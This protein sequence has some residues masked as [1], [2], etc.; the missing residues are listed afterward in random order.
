MTRRERSFRILAGILSVMMLYVAVQNGSELVEDGWLVSR[1]ALVIGMYLLIPM[2]GLY[3][4]GGQRAVDPVIG[5][6]MKA[7]E[8]RDQMLDKLIGKYVEM[9]PQPEH[10]LPRRKRSEEAQPASDVS[11]AEDDRG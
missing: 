7:A 6:L 8:L 1:W 10:L 5:W 3:A 11:I 2:F 9:P 4:I